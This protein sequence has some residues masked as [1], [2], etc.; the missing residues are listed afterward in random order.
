LL[1]DWEARPGDLPRTDLWWIGSVA[2]P[3]DESTD[4]RDFVA[5]LEAAHA[6]EDVDGYVEHLA[7][8]TVW[9]AGRWATADEMPWATTSGR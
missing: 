8:D 9:K 6:R 5:D 2:A 4:M 7:P 1:G 3:L